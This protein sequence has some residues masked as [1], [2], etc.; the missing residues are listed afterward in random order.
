MLLPDEPSSSF[1]YRIEDKIGEGSM[2]AVFF[3]RD[4]KLDRKVAIKTLRQEVISA[5][6]KDAAEKISQRFLQEARAA[7][8]LSHPGVASIY[9]MGVA[10]D[11]AFIAM[12]WLEGET[13]R[14]RID[15][16]APLPVEE[17]R[18][19]ALELLDILEDAHDNGI[20]H[21]DLK[22]ANIIVSDGT[23]RLTDFG[24]AHVGDSELIQTQAGAILGTPA[25]ASPEQIR[26]DEI[27]PR[28]DLYA[29][30]V[31]LFEMVT[32]HL[33]IKGDNVASILNN[34]LETTP[35][36]PGEFVDL[37][38]P[39][40]S[41]I[42][43]ALRKERSDRFNSA[44]HMAVRIG[45]EKSRLDGRDLR[46]TETP[47]E[48]IEFA[49]T[50]LPVDEQGETIVVE[51]ETSRE[52][53]VDTVHQ[54]ESRELG[55]Q[56]P[57]ALFEKV[58]DT[59][60]HAEP[61]AGAVDIGSS[62][63]LIGEGLVFGAIDLDTGE[64]GDRVY[65]SLPDRAPTRLYALPDE[66]SSRLIMNLASVLYP[67]N[68][69]HSD[70]DTSF[71]DINQL[72]DRLCEEE[73]SGIITFEDDNR[74]AHLFLHRG[75]LELEIFSDGWAVDPRDHPW[76][77]WIHDRSVKAHVE[78]R[79]TILLSI[80]YEMELEGQV[81][82]VEPHD[83]S[84][85][86]SEAVDTLERA[87]WTIDPADSRRPQSAERSSV[88]LRNLYASDRMCKCLR[89]MLRKLPGFLDERDRFEE[90]K[91]L[92][93][94]VGAVRR[95]HLYD[96]LPRPSGTG[97][98]S[99][100]LITFDDEDKVLHVAD[101][102]A[103]V[104]PIRLKQFADKVTEAKEARLETGDIGGAFILGSTFVS[105]CNEAYH[106]LTAQG[107]EES[108]LFNLQDSMTGYEGFVRIGTRRGFHLMMVDVQ[109]E[110]FHPRLPPLN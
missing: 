93:Q 92:S 5:L 25:Y 71:T 27:D 102:Y 23:P 65:E 69:L 96:R 87:N 62:L 49:R 24:V 110:G 100:D 52:L 13:L 29:V 33:P 20:V 89:W 67:P 16:Q 81:F 18:D 106:D 77:E 44:E 6:S 80:S 47:R 51:G 66:L 97:S 3:A 37:P 10:N 4:E 1:P 22:P 86:D 28:A 95:A 72:V 46:G 41:S 78:K 7:A 2:G 60:I 75:T 68:R 104:T 31:L 103:E 73:F 15:D 11:A 109:N 76:P 43:R 26:D 57:E 34:I 108:W 90:W 12:E 88:L 107:E 98:D 91:Y 8:R 105:G 79:R 32:G 38:S 83:L 99:F 48:S 55:T 35:P 14:D 70:L 53:V 54:W 82:S 45:G 30:G 36:R 9:Q 63:F 42:M 84:L 74:L 56:S 50:T 64:T 17:A 39:L 40:E 94:W 58:L 61:F 19:I 85:N 101:R 59:P 21:R